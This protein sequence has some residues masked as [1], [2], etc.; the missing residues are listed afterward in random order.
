MSYTLEE[1]IELEQ[2][3]IDEERE[4]ERITCGQ[5]KEDAIMANYAKSAK[6]KFAHFA[7][8]TIQIP[9]NLD[10]AQTRHKAYRDKLIAVGQTFQEATFNADC[11]VMKHYGLIFDI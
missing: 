4:H 2:Q 9:V 6:Y 1:H 3:R 10:E 11:Q 7:P 5:D 8:R